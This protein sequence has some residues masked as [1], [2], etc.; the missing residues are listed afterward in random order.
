MMI[1]AVNFF[2][3]RCKF[4]GSL[5]MSAFSYLSLLNLFFTLSIIYFAGL[6]LIHENITYIFC[7][8]LKLPGSRP[9]PRCRWEPQVQGSTIYV[10]LLG[11]STTSSVIGAFLAWNLACIY[12]CTLRRMAHL[13]LCSVSTPLRHTWA[14]SVGGFLI[15]VLTSLR[16]ATAQRPGVSRCRRPTEAV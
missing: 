9:I 13:V 4:F 6:V 5:F 1:W 8:T 11:Q 10:P 7:I 2:I 14:P 3:F 16:S 15:V 12:S